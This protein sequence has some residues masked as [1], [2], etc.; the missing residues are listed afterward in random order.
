M[1]SQQFSWQ[2]RAACKG[3]PSY[4]FFPDEERPAENQPGYDPRYATKTYQDFCSNC[5]VMWKCRESAELHDLQGYWG[6]LSEKERDASSS[7]EDRTYLREIKEEDG[8][9]W[10]LYGHS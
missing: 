8:E 1:G 9:Y 5:P 4:I 7:P 6:N 10:P 3:V 2:K